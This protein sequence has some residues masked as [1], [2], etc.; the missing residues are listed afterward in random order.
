M[1]LII[2][3]ESETESKEEREKRGEIMK[4]KEMEKNPGDIKRMKEEET[5]GFE[6]KDRIQSPWLTLTDD[7]THFHHL[8]QMK[9]EEGRQ[10]TALESEAQEKTR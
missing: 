4:E 1:A 5:E 10:K 2:S 3:W 6:R 9:W 7:W 8:M